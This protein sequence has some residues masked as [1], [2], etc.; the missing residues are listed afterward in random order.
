L[1]GTSQHKEGAVVAVKEG[2]KNGKE[3]KVKPE[4]QEGS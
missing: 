2:K 3:K 4:P 1:L